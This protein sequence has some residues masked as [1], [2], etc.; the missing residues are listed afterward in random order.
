M[1]YEELKFIAEIGINSN[2]SLQSAVDIIKL[3]KKVGFDYVKFQKRDPNICVP[4]NQ[5]DEPK[6][7]P[8]SN[9]PITYLQYKNA[10]EFEIEEYEYL[11]V[12]CESL[13]M[14]WFVSVWDIN[15]ADDM[16]QF[17]MP[18]VKIPSAKLT[19]DN[20]LFFCR[21][22]YD[23]I[24]LSTGMS[25]QDEID[26]AVFEYQPDIL[27]HTNSNYPTP[28]E[29]INLSY[30]WYMNVVYGKTYSYGYSNH[31]PDITAIYSAAIYPY[32]EFIEMHVTDD[33]TKWGSDQ[34]SSFDL[35]HGNL[36][37]HISI[38]KKMRENH[39][40]IYRGDKP[41]ELYPGEDIKKKSLR[42]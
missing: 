40:D 15:S 26:N 14:P 41:R 29:E 17:H 23:N 1:I 22:N 24:V 18:F 21:E 11:D 38:I 30:I 9:L 6:Q 33:P 32:L 19:D 12:I 3:A 34:A 35:V 36:R 2:G 25:T 39:T 20:L 27:F 4:E 37:E 8:W 13:D 28:L 7:V 5:K 31:C 16:L 10:M 42:G